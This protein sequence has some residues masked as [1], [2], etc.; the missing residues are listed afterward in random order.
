M[1]FQYCDHGNC[2][3]WV[4]S[5]KKTT[6]LQYTCNIFRFSTRSTLWDLRKPSRKFLRCATEALLRCASADSGFYPEYQNFSYQVSH[7][8]IFKTFRWQEQCEVS[9]LLN[10][11]HYITHTRVHAHT[12]THTI[13]GQLLTPRL[14]PV[15]QTW[16]QATSVMER[17]GAEQTNAEKHAANKHTV[18]CR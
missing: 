18:N 4:R 1:S 8:L 13:N 10:F 17:K 5:R 2:I 9:N 14:R 16:F 12:L 11:A 3:S 6:N 7:K 15:W